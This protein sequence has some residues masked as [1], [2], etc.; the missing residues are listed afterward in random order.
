MAIKSNSY[1]FSNDLAR[2]GSALSR[3]MIGNAQ[4]DAAIARGRY[5]DAQTQ[6]QNLQNRGMEGNLDAIDAASGGN[7]MRRSIAN[8]L[9]YDVNNGNLIQPVLPGGPQRSVPAIGADQVNMDG[10]ALMTEL[11]NIARTLFGDGTSNASQVA[12]ALDTLGGAGTSRLAESMIL[13]GDNNQAQRGALRLAPQGGQYQN[14]GFAMNQLRTQD[15]TNRLDDRLDREATMD[16]NQKVLEASKFRTNE[17]EKTKRFKPIILGQNQVAFDAKGDRIGN[18][19]GPTSP[20]KP[21][22]LKKGETA[23]DVDGTEIASVAGGPAII[24]LT[25]GQVA[26]VEDPDAEGGYTEVRGSNDKQPK[27]IV[28][29]PGQTVVTI[30]NDGNVISTKTVDDD[31]ITV[32]ANEGQ[33]VQLIVDDPQN[34]GEKKVIYTLKGQ[35]KASSTTSTDTGFALSASDDNALRDAFDTALANNNFKL[36]DVVQRSLRDVLVEQSL[37]NMGSKKNITRGVNY[38]SAQLRKGFTEVTIPNTGSITSFGQDTKI[39][40]PNFALDNLRGKLSG[41]D[42]QAAFNALN[43]APKQQV[44]GIFAS[45]G[46]SDAQINAIIGVL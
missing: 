16:S 42:K 7:V 35:P 20:D 22:I 6:G 38:I 39:Q 24:K 41:N 21:I 43:P 29:S 40:V 8:S 26:M 13:S 11:G 17:Q 25:E 10:G 12:S 15:A 37:A 4:D 27:S 5:Y 2:I 23:F 45:L 31:P 18:A 1:N 36:P 30:G 34:P 9:G 44:R 19:A 46:Y 3:A 32:K 28:A 33:T 14:P